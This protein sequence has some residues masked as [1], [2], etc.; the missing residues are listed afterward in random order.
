[1]A[2]AALALGANIGDP[3]QQIE[4]AISAINLHPEIDVIA[5]ASTIVSKAW[6]KTDQPDFFNSAVL[7]ET[8]LE[9]LV[10]LDAV[11]GI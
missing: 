3:A 8:A 9:P 6:G 10:L 4:D 7:V 5:R 1:M 11:L 2:L